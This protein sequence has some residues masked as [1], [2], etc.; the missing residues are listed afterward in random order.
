MGN[1]STSKGNRRK[2]LGK[3]ERAKQR[4]ELSLS[5][6]EVPAGGNPEPSKKAN[7][8]KTPPKV[9]PP[10]TS[11]TRPSS[12]GENPQKK[13][14]KVKPKKAKPNQGKPQQVKPDRVKPKQVKPDTQFWRAIVAR[15][16]W[17]HSFTPEEQLT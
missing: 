10:G 9:V 6:E 2:R 8:G 11:A 7:N 14:S 12:D 4:L 13:S 16:A 17:N 3:K 5:G 1:A 15:G